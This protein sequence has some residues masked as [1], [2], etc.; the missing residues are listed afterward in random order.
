MTTPNLSFVPGTGNLWLCQT[1]SGMGF[2][3]EQKGTWR[4]DR[5]NEPA[6]WN[7]SSSTAFWVGCSCGQ[8]ESRDLAIEAALASLRSAG[9]NLELLPRVA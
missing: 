6:W 2:H 9:C 7:W 3:V 8:A 5:D 1:E 4:L